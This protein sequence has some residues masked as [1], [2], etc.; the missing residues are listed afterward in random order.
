[1]I[2]YASDSLNIDTIRDV[3]GIIKENVYFD[4]IQAIEKRDN[5][6]II[7]KINQLINS[8]FSISNFINGFNEYLRNCMLQKIDYSGGNNISSDS[9]KW[10]Q[11]NCRL[12]TTDF[13]RMLDL[14][15]QFESNLKFIKEPLV[16]MEALFIKLSLMDSS[17]NIAHFL[18]GNKQKVVREK[19]QK[20]SEKS[21]TPINIPV[22]EKL[23]PVT[24]SSSPLESQADNKNKLTLKDITNSWDEIITQLDKKNSK[25]AHFL[26]ESKLCGFDGKE[27]LI[28]II[29][30]Q[31]FHLKTLDKDTEQIESVMNDILNQKIRIKFHIQ[32]ST[33]KTKNVEKK[34]SEKT[35]HPLFIKVLETF[36]GEI[37]R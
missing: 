12:T 23:T 4:I 19:A 34:T 8:G 6:D 7:Y 27:I 32:K 18:S 36:E 21:N 17:I 24:N 10:L 2:A 33:D 35:D 29:N 3:L 26:E 37:I 20:T 15:L 1:M 28:E 9:Q 16:S 14:S 5:E 13:L 11:G 30:G 25:I 22:T 31:K